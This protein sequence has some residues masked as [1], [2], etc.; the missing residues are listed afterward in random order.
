MK[1]VMG[2]DEKTHLTDVVAQELTRRGHVVELRGPL[3][4]EGLNW[5]QVAQAVAEDVASGK[6]DEG[7]LFC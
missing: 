4:G 3:R 7:I 5:T 1:L 2:S 6:A